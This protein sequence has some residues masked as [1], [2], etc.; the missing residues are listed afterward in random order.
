M[1]KT[2]ILKYENGKKK[3][4]GEHKNG[5]PEGKG[6]EYDENSNKSYEGD[7]KNGVPDGR[8]ISYYK[9]G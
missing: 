2:I 1:S 6:I 5:V 9:D 4:E 3:Y 7:F 8:G